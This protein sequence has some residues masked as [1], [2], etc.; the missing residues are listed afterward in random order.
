M[1]FRS[2]SQS[3]YKQTERAM[4]ELKVKDTTG[5][6]HNLDLIPGEEPA[7]TYQVNDIAELKDRQAD[8]S[9]K[10]NLPKTSTNFWHHTNKLA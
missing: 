1:L 3:R 2:V 7:M 9:Q 8:Y 5:V 6:W 10:L 4:Y